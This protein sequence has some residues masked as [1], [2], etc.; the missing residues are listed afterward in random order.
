MDPY[1]LVS[2][3]GTQTHHYIVDKRLT[4]GRQDTAR[5]DPPP[6]D[7]RDDDGELKLVVVDEEDL[8]MPRAWFAV[9]PD[10]EAGFSVKNIH[11]SMAVEF[12]EEDSP[13]DSGN[14]RQFD[15]S[16]SIDL[17]NGIE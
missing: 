5:N 16:V 11:T 13:I 9:I 12:R 4:V 14:S 3:D 6:I 8:R 15:E 17:G 1:L 10:V 7:L 2:R